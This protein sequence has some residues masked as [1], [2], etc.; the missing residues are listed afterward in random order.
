VELT[1]RTAMLPHYAGLVLLNALVPLVGLLVALL[2]EVRDHAHRGVGLRAATRVHAPVVV[3]TVV[4]VA[5]LAVTTADL[6]A[7]AVEG[8]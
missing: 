6:A 1:G 3:A 2:L 7:V 4:L 5:G 8:L